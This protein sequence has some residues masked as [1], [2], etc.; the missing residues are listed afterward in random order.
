MRRQWFAAGSLIALLLAC[1]VMLS[2]CSVIGLDSKALMS[3]PREDGDRGSIHSL[4]IDTVGG[5]ITFR[6]PRKGEY[7]SAIVTKDFTGDRQE[8]AIALYEASDNSGGTIISFMTKKNGEWTVI[9]S[10]ANTAVQVDRICFADLDDDGILEVVIGWGSSTLNSCTACVYDYTQDGVIEYPMEQGYGEMTVTN[11]VDEAQDEL[12]IVTLATDTTEAVAE[13]VRMSQGSLQIVEATTLDSTVVQYAQI[14]AGLIAQNQK[15]ILVDG[16]RADSSMITQII[17]WN[18]KENKL[19]AP[20]STSTSQNMNVTSRNAAAAYTS[21]DIDGNSIIEFPI[22]N[23]LPGSQ[24]NTKDSAAYLINWSQFDVEGQ[25]PVRVMS[26]VNNSNDGFWILFP[27]IWRDKVTCKSDAS[28]HSTTFYEWLADDGKGNPASGAAILKIQVFTAEDWAVN[29]QGYEQ[30]A[31]RA[32]LVY[33]ASI[34]EP[35]HEL[36]LSIEEIQDSF[37]FLYTE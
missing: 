3:P 14:S 32:G 21:R 8:N 26:T 12:F 2:G 29:S 1:L 11:L 25:V 33:A 16:L 13:I 28:T 15:G 34:P 31:E 18:K 23:L 9:R 27:E 36:A 35:G 17:Y 6:Y 10:F 24:E 4:L 7:R 20:Y 37:H 5:E 19:V 30:I 22:V